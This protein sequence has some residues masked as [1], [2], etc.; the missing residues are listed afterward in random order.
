M[1]NTPEEERA[2]L[3]RLG[4]RVEQAAQDAQDELLSDLDSDAPVRES[5]SAAL[6]S[7]RADVIEALASG[8]AE[9]TGKEVTADA[10][11]SLMIGGRT[12]ADALAGEAENAATI[13]AAV[14]AD[15][16]AAFDEI[17]R[18]AKALVNAYKP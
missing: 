7:F 17:E 18:R 13:A 5:A 3:D 2:L 15:H 16:R 10:A 8:I 9:V 1:I 14:V 6:L 11:G 12:I 4:A